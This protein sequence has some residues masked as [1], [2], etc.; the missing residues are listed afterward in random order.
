MC[1]PF[2]TQEGLYFYSDLS[3]NDQ[4][5]CTRYHIRSVPC[6]SKRAKGFQ[7]TD[8]VAPFDESMGDCTDSSTSGP[9]LPLA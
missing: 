9:F 8:Q 4:C 2:A 1:R 7:L 3:S 5:G 6:S